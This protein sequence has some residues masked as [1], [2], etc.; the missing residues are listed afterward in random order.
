MTLR[1]L[2]PEAMDALDAAYARAVMV[3]D[4]SLMELIADRIA[5][6]LA[7]DR[8][9][10]EATTDRERAACAVIDQA[11]VDV[12]GIEDE[13]VRHAAS[14]FDDGELADLVMAAYIVEARTRLGIASD[15]LLGGLG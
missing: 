9:G 14:Y 10:C 13:T 4:P 2:Q 11:L 3:V 1:D 12:A 7:G 5:V 8:P 6:T 15:R